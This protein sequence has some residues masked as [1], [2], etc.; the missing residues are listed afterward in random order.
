MLSSNMGE[1]YLFT[2]DGLLAAT[3]WNDYR[4]PGVLNWDFPVVRR[5]MSLDNVTLS[6]EHFGGGFYRTADGKFYLVAGHNHFS[7]A[8]IQGFETMKRQESTLTLTKDDLAAADLWQTRQAVAAAAQEAP[9]MVVAA[10]PQV[11]VQPD[12]D[13]KEWK[14]EQFVAVA[15]RGAF[16][17]S[18]D[19]KN[20]Y[21]AWRVD[22]GQPLRNAGEDFTMLF[23]T[24]DS[25][26]L[27]IGVDDT[28][29]LARS[30]PVPGDQRL[31]ITL[32]K[33]Q[34]VGVLYRHRVPGVTQADRIGFT[35]PQSTEYVDR[36]DRLDPAHIGIKPIPG[37]YAVEAVVPFELL[38][39]KPEPGK[40]YKIDFGILSADSSGGATVA[41]TY[42]ANQA[43]GLV[44]D[45]PGEIR[46][47]PGLWG[48]IRLRDEPLK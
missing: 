1:W 27:L 4:I 38:G 33:G 40:S 22:S 46:L 25:V 41:R 31:L 28:A 21:L 10:A 47:T 29:D 20:L 23:K 37:G 6:G 5:G 11:L 32:M 16:A 14:P 15:K 45:V 9:K 19:E 17:V 48:N 8:E 13:L 12:G 35:S 3:V 18:T 44:S 7:L 2:A 43:T 30:A 42:W 26:D 24:G 39:L 34:P 36:I